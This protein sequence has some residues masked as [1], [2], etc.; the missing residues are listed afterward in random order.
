[1]ILAPVLVYFESIQQLFEE[2]S[3]ISRK[4]LMKQLDQRID[5]IEYKAL[6]KLFGHVHEKIKNY[7]DEPFNPNLIYENWN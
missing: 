1:M 4:E 7:F 2:K 3:K 5:Q 6:E